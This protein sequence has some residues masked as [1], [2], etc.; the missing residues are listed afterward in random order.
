MTVGFWVLFGLLALAGIGITII[1]FLSDAPVGGVI[2][3]LITV[4]VLGGLLWFG[5]WYYNNT[6]SGARAV[7]DQQLDW[8]QGVERIIQVIDEKQGCTGAASIILI[9]HGCK[10]LFTKQCSVAA[11]GQRG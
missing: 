3:L 10:I 4:I 5:S 9:A 7:K 1:C 11:G 2:T 6:A 8:S